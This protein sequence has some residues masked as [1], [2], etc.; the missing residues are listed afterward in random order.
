MGCWNWTGINQASKCHHRN[1]IM[2]ILWLRHRLTLYVTCLS[3]WKWW[4]ARL[5]LSLVRSLRTKRVHKWGGCV[6]V[7]ASKQLSKIVCGRVEYTMSQYWAC[8]RSSALAYT[9]RVRHG[10][11]IERL[12]IRC[13]L[14]PYFQL[15]NIYCATNGNVGIVGVSVC[16]ARVIRGHAIEGYTDDNSEY[17]TWLRGDR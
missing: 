2:R 14:T 7:S 11:A 4:E 15:I 8:I 13:P 16:H 9:L 6:P 5:E 17:R 12:T 1:N 3:P 10:E